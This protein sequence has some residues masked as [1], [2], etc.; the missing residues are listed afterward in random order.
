[1]SVSTLYIKR[2]KLAPTVTFSCTRNFACKNLRAKPFY[3]HENQCT[4]IL[5]LSSPEVVGQSYIYEY[6][7]LI[8]ILF[9][10]T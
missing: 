7:Y 1:M 4:Q 9:Y 2:C 8:F 5:N 3:V 10:L 6:F